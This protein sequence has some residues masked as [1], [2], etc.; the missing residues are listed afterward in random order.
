MET[1]YIGNMIAYEKNRR[2]LTAEVV[3]RGICEQSVYSRIENGNYTG[4]I[5]LVMAVLGRLGISGSKAGKYLCRDEYDEMQARFN[6]LEYIRSADLE[7]I[8]I[9]IKEYS[10]KYCD[11]SRLKRNQLRGKNLKIF[12]E[13]IL[14]MTLIF[15][16]TLCYASDGEVVEVNDNNAFGL[17][18][19]QQET[20][21]IGLR[22]SNTDIVVYFDLHYAWE[23]GYTSWFTGAE[24]KADV[25]DGHTVIIYGLTH[26]ADGNSSNITVTIDMEYEKLRFNVSKS[27]YVDEYGNL[28][29]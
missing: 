27:F 4:D 29:Y 10:D 6:V 12:M 3:H 16:N 9:A 21:H 25:P 19:S 2:G 23:E 24:L 5:H 15:G 8:E 26:N 18:R 7:K 1:E 28:S 11:K 20:K 13:L 17:A 22:I 14:A